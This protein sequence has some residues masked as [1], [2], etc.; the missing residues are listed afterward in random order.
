M[1]RT[2]GSRSIFSAR[3]TVI[4]MS[5]VLLTGCGAGPNAPTRLI[6]QVTDGVEKQVGEVK[7]LHLLLVKQPDGSAVL[8]GT[9]I[10]NGQSPDLITNMTA[11]GIPAQVSPTT[12]LASPEQP[13]IFAGESANAIAVFPGLNV[14]PGRHAS[15]QITLRNSGSVTVDTLVRDR[16]GEFAN[17]G[18]TLVTN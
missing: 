17:V 3:I 7:L 11:N 18:P 12:L 2:T 16:I 1:Q 4:A 9:V 5:L 14:K 13:L 8:V 6:K 15:L 10:N